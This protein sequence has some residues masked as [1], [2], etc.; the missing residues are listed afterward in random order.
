MDGRVDPLPALGFK[1]GDANIM[2]NAGAHSR[3]AIRSILLS[4]HILGT[5]QVFIIKHTDCGMLKATTELAHS[6]MKEN[7]G[8]NESKDID[9]FEVMPI[10]DLQKSAED[11]VMFLR[12][13]PLALG[14]VKV[15][16]WILDID[17][18]L[19]KRVVD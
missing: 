3:D 7:L 8:R 16:G 6:V 5:D 2:R 11:D 9:E 19:L 10:E 15:T 18:G 14:K 4:N 17:T 1:R 12:N 13:H